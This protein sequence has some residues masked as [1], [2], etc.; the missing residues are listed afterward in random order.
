M[1][2]GPQIK[3]FPAKFH[4][5]TLLTKP[6]IT[7]L[8]N[9]GKIKTNSFCNEIV[10]ITDNN[11]RYI[12]RRNPIRQQEI[13]R[14]REDKMIAIEKLLSRENEYLRNHSKASVAAAVKRISEKIKKLKV[15]K[16]VK[17]EV[18]KR[19]MVIIRD[20]MALA[21]ESA[22]DGC[23]VIK[24][25]VPET[26]IGSTSQ[27]IHDRYKDLSEVEY[28]FRTMKTAHLELRPHYVRKACR[29]EGHVFVVM[30]AYKLLRHLSRAWSDLNV[31]AE[32]GVHILS[33]LCLMHTKGVEGA[34]FIPQPRE[35]AQELLKL[36][37][38]KLPPIIAT[39][40][41]V[42]ATRKKLQS[43]RVTH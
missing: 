29:T 30:L 22:L 4:Y 43:E 41:V 8:L 24:T 35:L 26:I 7:T 34:G 3:R 13:Q 42:V 1:I 11:V 20:D 12:L 33:S 16:W 28:A 2:K 19:E 32:E 6:Q 21:E 38:V 36:I 25:D 5:I 14:N 31:T 15:S 17:C 18:S 27:D 9:S 10:E 37:D 39:K 40:G 23:Y